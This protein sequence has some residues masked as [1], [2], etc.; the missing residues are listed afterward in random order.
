LKILQA[1]VQV[2]LLNAIVPLKELP[3]FKKQNATKSAKIRTRH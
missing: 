2:I 1:L 3:S